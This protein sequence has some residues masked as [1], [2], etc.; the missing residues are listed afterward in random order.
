MFF[1]KSFFFEFGMKQIDLKKKCVNYSLINKFEICELN[2]FCL[3]FNF[4]VFLRR[5][6]ISHSNAF[7]L[8]Y[9]SSYIKF[10]ISFL[11][12][13]STYADSLVKIIEYIYFCNHLLKQ[14]HLRGIKLYSNCK[15][16][17]LFTAICVSLP[18]TSLALQ[19]VRPYTQY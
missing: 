13:I 19:N 7:D 5:N 1:Y 2:S 9:F 17:I 15:F 4:L 6:S 10:K 11:L 14:T 3:A 18:K 16:S 12:N 8:I